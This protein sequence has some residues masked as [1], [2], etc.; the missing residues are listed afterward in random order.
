MKPMPHPRAAAG[1]T[2]AAIA[3]IALALPGCVSTSDPPSAVCVPELS[4]SPD[5]P[6]PGRIVTVA[7]T[8]PCPAP[9]GT[10]WVVRIQRVD[11]RIPLAQ[12]RVKPEPDGSFEVSITVPPTIHPGTAIAWISNYWDTVECPGGGSCVSPE[13]EFTV[14]AP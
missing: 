3:L 8:H 4:V 6:K 2:F 13:E 5:N 11:E 1:M 9:E 7:T 14:A 10:E 12:A